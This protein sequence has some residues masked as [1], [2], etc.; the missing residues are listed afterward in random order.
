MRLTCNADVGQFV[1]SMSAALF[2]GGIDMRPSTQGVSM[3]LFWM[4]I[5]NWCRYCQNV[6]F[7]LY[8]EGNRHVLEPVHI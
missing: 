4:R 6:A 8:T 7:Q 3:Q 1:P 2:Q 5:F